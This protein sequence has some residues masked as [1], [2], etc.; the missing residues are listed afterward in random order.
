MTSQSGLQTIA[1]YILLNISQNNGNQ[2]MKLGQLT[3]CSKIIFSSKIM[4]K[5]RQED[6]FQASFYFFEKAYYEMKAIGLQL[7]FDILR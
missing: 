4:R 5:M 2:T 7:N 6:L 1:I 3:E